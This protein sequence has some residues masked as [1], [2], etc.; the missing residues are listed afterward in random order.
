MYL[1]TG[2]IKKCGIVKSIMLVKTMLKD[3]QRRHAFSVKQFSLSPQDPIKDLTILRIYAELDKFKEIG[4]EV[5]GGEEE[6]TYEWQDVCEIDEVEGEKV[7]NANQQVE[8]LVLARRLHSEEWGCRYKAYLPSPFEN[9]I[10]ETQLDLIPPYLQDKAED[11]NLRVWENISLLCPTAELEAKYR[12][13]GE[14]IRDLPPTVV[15]SRLLW[16]LPRPY[17][18]VDITS[19]IYT[20]PTTVLTEEEECK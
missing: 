13:S 5:P 16:R 19:A 11:L 10:R 12:E 2:K 8:L 3:V 1:Y 18:I 15:G 7:V 9:G 6:K 4:S 17:F 14:Q 20:P